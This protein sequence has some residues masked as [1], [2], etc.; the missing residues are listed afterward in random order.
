MFQ[1]TQNARQ[2]VR[3][4]TGFYVMA[5]RFR[6]AE[7][8]QYVDALQQKGPPMPVNLQH[9]SSSPMVHIHQPSQQ[10]WQSVA[11]WGTMVAQFCLVAIIAWKLFGDSGQPVAQQAASAATS[12][13]DA[14]LEAE[15][16]DRVV[17]ELRDTPEGFTDRMRA[18][19]LRSQELEQRLET[20]QRQHQALLNQLDADRSASKSTI[21]SLEASLA[22]RD[23]QI[24]S[25]KNRL[26]EAQAEV[27]ARD[28]QL[29]AAGLGKKSKGDT[30]GEKSE[31]ATELAGW[32][33]WWVYLTAGVAGV[34]AIGCVVAA[35][36]M[37]R[38]NEFEEELEQSATS[39]PSADGADAEA[40]VPRDG[41]SA[42]VTRAEIDDA[43]RPVEASRRDH[44]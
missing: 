18:E 43:D 2:R 15:F 36:S 40:R 17:Q 4:T 37:R 19:F 6:A 34:L 23:H 10:G 35:V 33:S 32:K 38:K 13:H 25:L 39:G 14:A 30:E 20:E 3:R 7:L 1:W 22:K 26:A 24:E 5:S 27:E 16:L 44:S 31:E 21:T 29:A 42:G 12:K 8:E 41:R 11:V 28:E 9:G